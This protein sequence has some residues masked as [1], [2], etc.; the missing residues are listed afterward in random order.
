[1]TELSKFESNLIRF[2]WIWSRLGFICHGVLTIQGNSDDAK[3][4]G[5]VVRETIILHLHSF[6]KVRSN[7]IGNSDFKKLDD[8]LQPLLRKILD[9]K[10]PIRKIRNGYIAHIQD[11]RSMKPFDLMIQE[12]VDKHHLPVAF[13]YWVA[14]AGAAHTYGKFVKINFADE[15]T[16][17]NRKYNAMSPMLLE[18]GR[19]DSSSMAMDK[20]NMLNDTKRILLSKGYKID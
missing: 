12:I 14:L 10:T 16:T 18:W 6:L 1:M 20:K 11:R 4:F 13:T 3:N 2:A 19:T 17:V 5:A 8:C 9:A 15:W 7:L